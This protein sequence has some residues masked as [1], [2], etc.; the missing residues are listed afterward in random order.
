MEYI[1]ESTFDFDTKDTEY[2]Y[3]IN[4]TTILHIKRINNGVATLYFTDET[5]NNINIPNGIVVYTIDYQINKKIIHNSIQQHYPLCWTD[6]Y[7]VELNK[8]V[9][10]NIKKQ[11]K[12]LIVS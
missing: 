4:S 9:L 1:M 11:R 2:I 8:S 5:N 6:D 12:W 10:V 3:N 7:I